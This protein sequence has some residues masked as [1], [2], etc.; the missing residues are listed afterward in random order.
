MRSRLVRLGI[1]A[2][3][4]LALCSCAQSKPTTT[5]AGALSASDPGSP[6]ASSSS[7]D[8]KPGEP[9]TRTELIG[10]WRP[11]LLAGRDSRFVRRVNGNR[12]TITFTM[13]ST[14]LAYS[15][16]DGCNWSS[17]R[18]RVQPAGQFSAP[19]LVTTTLRLCLGDGDPYA[20]NVDAA[21]KA[22][23]VLLDG[24]LL[25]FYDSTGSVLGEYR[26]TRP[27]L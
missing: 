25:R 6:V 22:S 26:R 19:G 14:G 23:R 12:L 5:D 21:T 1:V 18:A 11:L 24:S 15:A 3:F 4:G 17:G 20:S 16:Y 7:Q 13:R 10:T 9:P 27:G 2:V 8:R